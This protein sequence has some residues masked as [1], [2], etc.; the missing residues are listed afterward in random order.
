MSDELY[1]IIKVSV[2][3]AKLINAGKGIEQGM[4]GPRNPQHQQLLWL[5]TDLRCGL[6]TLLRFCATCA[7]HMKYFQPPTDKSSLLLKICE[8]IVRQPS[9]AIAGTLLIASRRHNTLCLENLYPERLGPGL[10]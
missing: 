8:L 2:G 10:A 6:V 7:F 3:S 4:E 5:T 1:P 9:K